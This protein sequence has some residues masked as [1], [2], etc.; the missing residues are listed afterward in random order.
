MLTSW[1][2]PSAA[3]E[4]GLRQAARL[5][6]DSEAGGDSLGRRLC[7]LSDDCCQEGDPSFVCH[8]CPGS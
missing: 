2:M 6:G 3:L 1:N 5:G 8:S 4:G 7:L